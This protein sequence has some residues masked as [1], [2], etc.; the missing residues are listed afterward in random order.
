MKR[1][2]IAGVSG[3]LF[4]SASAFAGVKLVN[5]DSASHEVKIKCSSTAISSIGGNSTRDLGNG[6]CTVTVTKTGASATS[7][8]GTL[9]IKNGGI[10][11]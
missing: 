5:K 10:S 4:F 7:S 9:T 1:I 2:A 11:S 8:G 6:P 3:L